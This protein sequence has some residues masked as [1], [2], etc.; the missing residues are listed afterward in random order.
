MYSAATTPFPA[1]VGAD[2]T[3]V[4]IDLSNT[5]DWTDWKYVEA[6]VP[7]TLQ[8]PIKLERIYLVETDPSL[9]TRGAI[10]MDDLTAIYPTS[11]PAAPSVQGAVKD[12]REAKAELSGDKAFRFAA[13][14]AVTGIDTLLDNLAV[15]K[16]A[17]IAN[18]DA[19]FSVFTDAIDSGFKSQLKNTVVH[20]NG[21]YTFTTHQDSIF[22]QLD[23]TKGGLRETNFAQW[24]WFLEAAAIIDAKSVFVLLPKAMVFSDRLEEK[25]FKDTLQKLKETRGADVWVL[26]GGSDEFRVTLDEGI[27]Y[28]ALKSYPT[29][30]DIDVFTQ[31]KYM[32]FTVNGD[33]VTY[34]ILPLYTK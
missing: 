13:H 17:E 7:A 26:H 12:T 4:N 10:Y 2:G 33:K 25:L 22:I 31:L 24:R 16:M 1:P 32:L 29:T 6:S 23:N 30:N 3:A 20:A 9:K 27:R 14:G 11:L 34:E 19:A 8:T 28:V 18:R 5:V 15:Q 21:G